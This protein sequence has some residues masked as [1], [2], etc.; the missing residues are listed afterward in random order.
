[1][2]RKFEDS[3]IGNVA[4]LKVN[5]KHATMS[6]AA[7]FR[8]FAGKVIDAGA[9]KI[10]V[11]MKS[12][13]IIDSTFIGALVSSLKKVTSIGGNLRLVIDSTPQSNIFMLTG[14]SKVFKIYPD[15]DEAVKSFE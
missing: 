14:I 5:L 4:V 1:M 12:C 3:F 8:E 15:L 9:N 6:D 7:R 13:L 11:D 2:Y 10:V